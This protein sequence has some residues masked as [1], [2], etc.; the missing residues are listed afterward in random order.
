MRY[1]KSNTNDMKLP[2]VTKSDGE[3]RRFSYDFLYLLINASYLVIVTVITP[4]TE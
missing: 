1:A 2:V 4:F 3:F